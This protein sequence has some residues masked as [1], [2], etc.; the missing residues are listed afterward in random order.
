MYLLQFNKSFFVLRELFRFVFAAQYGAMFVSEHPSLHVLVYSY[1]H[2]QTKI[3][4]L[5][6]QW[7]LSRV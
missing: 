7:I 2:H 3:T 5:A 6:R 1:F 4:S